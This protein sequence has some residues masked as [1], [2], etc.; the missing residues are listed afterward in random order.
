MNR[1]LRRKILD[2]IG[3]DVDKIMVSADPDLM[4]QVVYNLIENAV[5]FV[6]EGGYIEVKYHSDGAR[7]LVAIRNSGAGIAPQDL[8]NVFERFIKPTVPAA[9]IRPASALAFIL[10]VL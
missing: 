7:T 3:L 9:R 2:I 4:H 1:P 6:N 10:F 5:K 8:P